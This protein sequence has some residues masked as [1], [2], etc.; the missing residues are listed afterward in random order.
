[1]YNKNK[2][3]GEKCI[4]DEKVSNESSNVI[5]FGFI[6]LEGFQFRLLVDFNQS[7]TEKLKY[8]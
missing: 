4:F 5:R 6:E 7:V 3:Y 2:I 1:M 8:I